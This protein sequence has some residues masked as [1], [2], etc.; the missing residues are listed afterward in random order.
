VFEWDS[1]KAAAN[2]TKH[3]ISFDDG[4]TVFADPRT[5]DGPDAPHSSSEPRRRAIGKTDAGF[6]VVVAYT[7]RRTNYGEAIRI[8]SARPANR[9][10]RTKYAA[11]D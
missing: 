1:S 10:E 2:L 9:K 6:V 8:I 4:A 5:L 11:Q 7:I 3:G